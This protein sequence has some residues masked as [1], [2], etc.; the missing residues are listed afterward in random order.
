VKCLR[1]VKNE[2]IRS[3][4]DDGPYLISAILVVSNLP[5]DIAYHISGG[6]CT[7]LNGDV[8]V[9]HD[10]HHTSLSSLQ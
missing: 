10:M 8:G 3:L 1:R 2:L 9:L 6:R 5:E 4:P 7:S